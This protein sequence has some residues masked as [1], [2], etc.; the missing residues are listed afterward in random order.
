MVRRFHRLPTASTWSSGI[1]VELRQH[2]SR[3]SSPGRRG[4]LRGSGR[5]HRAYPP[6]ARTLGTRP[7]WPSQRSL[8]K[9]SP[10]HRALIAA[11]SATGGTR[12]RHGLLGT[13][14]AGLASRSP[15]SAPYS[16]R[17]GFSP[18]VPRGICCRDHASVPEWARLAQPLMQLSCSE[19]Q[20]RSLG[21]VVVI[22]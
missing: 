18:R 9:P 13:S 19:V 16:C 10:T 22:E 14:I 7:V 17:F 11:L 1:R 15:V 8:I 5:Q 3:S 4:R 20:D 6:V 2:S 12:V 21:R